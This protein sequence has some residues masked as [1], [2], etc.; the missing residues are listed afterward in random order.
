MKPNIF[1]IFQYISATCRV[2]V[3]NGDIVINPTLQELAQ[4]QLNMIVT[5]GPEEKVGMF[6]SIMSYLVVVIYVI[7]LQ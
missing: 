2:G 7:L 6:L 5:S 4:T 3:I 1:C